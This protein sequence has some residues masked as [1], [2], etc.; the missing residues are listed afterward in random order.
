M[1]RTDG[2]V[3]ENMKIA[4][5]DE[6]KITKIKAHDAIQIV[7][8]STH[9]IP[10]IDERYLTEAFEGMPMSVD[11]YVMVPYFGG[12]LKFQ[13]VKTNPEGSVV[14]TRSTSFVIED[15]KDEKKV[16]CPTCGSKV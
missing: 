7:V 11:D 5:D 3:R 14:V 16:T 2:I 6:I 8:K 10:S 9:A 4:I 1:A 13:V 12:R 15:N